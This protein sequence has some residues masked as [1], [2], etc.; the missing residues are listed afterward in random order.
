MSALVAVPLVTHAQVEN[1][2]TNPSFEEDE[3][4]LND[5]AYEHWWTWGWEAGLNSTLEIDETEFVDGK[6]SIRVIPTGETNWYFIVAN[7]PILVDMSKDYTISFWAKAE[8]PR[9]LT[10]QLKATDNSINA[11]GATTFNLTTEW[12]EYHY[13]SEVLID[14]V[15]LE[16]LCASSEVPFW[17]DFVYVYE[18][19]YVPGIK[20]V[21]PVKAS[22]P[23]PADG[24]FLDQTWATLSW[25]AGNSAVSHDVYMGDNF[26]DVNEGAGDTFRGNQALT[27]YV[28]G[29][30][31]MRIRTALLMARHTIGG[32]TRSTKLTQTA[33]GRATSGAS[34]LHPRP[35]T[36]PI[37]QTAPNPSIW[38]S[39]LNGGQV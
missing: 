36:S 31:D 21:P 34:L 9:P 11:W 13:A 19:D 15:K 38:T 32:L 7:S 2:V 17:L 33:P 30:P 4:I 37:R 22:E 23:D 39:S 20:P 35:P 24:V 26:D 3:P 12:T 28:A 16:I 18:G 5:Q 29:F 1:L 27:F 10:A 14:N 8:G 25:T 6:R